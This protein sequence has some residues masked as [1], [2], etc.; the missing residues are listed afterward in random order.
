MLG[1][2]EAGPGREGAV[3]CAWSCHSSQSLLGD[4]GTKDGR[5]CIFVMEH[6]WLRAG[7]QEVLRQRIQRWLHCCSDC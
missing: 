3:P 7:S 6:V 4:P 5:E 2:V 1:H